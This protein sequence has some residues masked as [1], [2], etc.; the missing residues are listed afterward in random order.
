MRRVHDDNVRL[1]GSALEFHAL[2][3]ENSTRVHNL[4]GQ[5]PGLP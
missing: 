5:V 3:R 2:F 1:S 4:L